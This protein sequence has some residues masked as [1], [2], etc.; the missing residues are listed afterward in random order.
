MEFSDVI[1]CSIGATKI[2]DETNKLRGFC[3]EGDLER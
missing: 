2:N 1:S 3:H